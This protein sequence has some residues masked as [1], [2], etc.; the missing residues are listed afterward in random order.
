MSGVIAGTAIGGYMGLGTAVGWL[1]G[2]AAG[3]SLGGALGG[4][5]GAGGAQGGGGAGAAD[6]Y[7]GYRGGAA[8]AYNQALL[9]GGMPIAQMPGYNQYQKNIVN[10]AMQASQRQGAAAGMLYSGGEKVALQG[11]AQQGYSNFYNDYLNRLAQASGATQNPANAV[12]LGLEANK[13]N[14]ANQQYY[15]GQLTQGLGNLSKLGFGSGNVT[16]TPS[17]A[18]TDPYLGTWT[19]NGPMTSSYSGQIFD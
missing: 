6:P 7:A 12:Q 18:Y 8:Q 19:S 5:L 3:A 17:S 16:P 13:Q 10:P 9:G 2:A 4:T 15:M 1:G 14:M 11:V